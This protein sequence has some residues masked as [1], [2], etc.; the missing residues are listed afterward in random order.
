MFASLSSSFI[1][2]EEHG[3]L[4]TSPEA[5]SFPPVKQ[6][7]DEPRLTATTNTW[8]ECGVHSISCLNDEQIWTSGDNKCMHLL[9]LQGKLLTSLQ[10]ESGNTPQD[11][12]MTRGGDL[13]L[14]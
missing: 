6:L 8:Y 7:L 12:S 11:I 14:Y 3:G 5:V 1:E 4:M 10:T 2:T 13:F 9:N